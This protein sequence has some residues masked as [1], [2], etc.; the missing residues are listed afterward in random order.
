MARDLRLCGWLN[1]VRVRELDGSEGRRLRRTDRR[2]TGPVVTWS[3]AQVVLLS[4]Q[5]MTVVKIAEVKFTSTDRVRDVFHNDN[6][7]GFDSLHPKYKG[8]RPRTFS[9]Q[10]VGRSLAAVG[11][12]SDGDQCAG[13]VEIVLAGLPSLGL[14]GRDTGVPGLG[15]RDQMVDVPRACDVEV[16]VVV[17]RVPTAPGGGVVRCDGWGSDGF[18]DQDFMDMVLLASR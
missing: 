16:G 14:P 5:G 1:G 9:S 15:E 17:G 10:N 3:R 2:G 7:D 13:V 18:F 4:A 11:S 8:G 12:G 6:A